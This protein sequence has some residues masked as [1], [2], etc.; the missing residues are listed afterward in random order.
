[1]N[2]FVQANLK[3]GESSDATGREPGDLT[4]LLAARMVLSESVADPL[5]STMSLQ[6]DPVVQEAADPADMR[7]LDN[8]AGLHLQFDAAP[9]PALA[10]AVSSGMV[11]DDLL[12]E[13]IQSLSV[14]D[15]ASI[16]VT[17]PTRP[18]LPG[19]E[20]SI[21]PSLAT[22]TLGTVVD[23]SPASQAETSPR[24]QQVSPESE[25]TTQDILVA[26]IVD[27][28]AAGKFSAKSSILKWQGSIARLFATSDSEPRRAGDWRELMAAVLPVGSQCPKA[29]DSVPMSSVP[30]PKFSASAGVMTELLDALDGSA[31][32]AACAE[33]EPPAE[34]PGESKRI[35]RASRSSEESLRG[36]PQSPPTVAAEPQ[37]AVAP[38]PLA[39]RFVSMLLLAI[40]VLLLANLVAMLFLTKR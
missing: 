23:V 36:V 27:S 29:A 20:P 26:G 22:T 8:T 10:A 31:N 38:S 6:V 17:V 34:A 1:M 13:L 28:S 18:S 39:S 3:V 35:V 14:A 2:E 16:R 19:Q 37:P 25:A 7:D 21:D 24:K 5:L 15:A 12:S 32:S 33:P 4:R 40:V 30:A 9:R 11:D